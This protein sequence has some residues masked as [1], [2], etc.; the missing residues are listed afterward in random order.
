MTTTE[1]DTYALRAACRQCGAIV[2]YRTL[3]GHQDVVRCKHGHF[4]YNAPKTETGRAPRTVTTV[5]NG[6]K[7]SQRAAILMRASGR[8]EM[9]GA[10]PSASLLHVSHFLSVD[11]GIKAE[12]P[13]DV[14]ND[15]ENLCCL[16]EE[17]NLGVGKRTMPLRLAAAILRARVATSRNLR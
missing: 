16:C 14:I 1:H 8:C 10:T 4:C 13:D 3:I 5:H 12:L 15:D 11:D 6:I 7:P 17:C 2:G 9:C